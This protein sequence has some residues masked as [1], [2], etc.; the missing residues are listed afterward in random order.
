[1]I[2]L[3]MEINFIDELTDDNIILLDEQV[4][5]VY[6]TLTAFLMPSTQGN[7]S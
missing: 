3:G 1:M 2:I 4:K 6:I 7:I 5:Q